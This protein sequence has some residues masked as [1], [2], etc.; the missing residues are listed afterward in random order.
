MTCRRDWAW[1]HAGRWQLGLEQFKSG[2]KLIARTRGAYHWAAA[3]ARRP[4]AR[5]EPKC[6]DGQGHGARVRMCVCACTSTMLGIWRVLPVEHAASQDPPGPPH[7]PAGSSTPTMTCYAPSPCEKSGH[8]PS[9]P[10]RFDWH[11]QSNLV[12][13]QPWSLIQSEDWSHPRPC[14]GWCFS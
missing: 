10:E 12:T 2:L 3:P 8:I 7:G 1:E 11:F 13:L 4:P 9:E 6:V 14:P 5:R